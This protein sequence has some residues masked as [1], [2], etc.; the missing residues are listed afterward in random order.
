M[1]ENQM[2]SNRWVRIMGAIAVA[3]CAAALV[4]GV[5]LVRADDAAK[6]S[7]K[8]IMKADHKGDKSLAKKVGSGKATPDEVAKLLADYKIIADEKPPAGTQDDWTMR[9][10][11]LITATQA[12]QS[13]DK[14][15][16]DQ[17]KAAVSCKACHE[18]HKEKE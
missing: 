15:G 11:K 8:D 7:I 4:I 12:I 3:G 1:L 14:A 6:P 16:P 2:R 13:G 9:M 10:T 5:P 18:L 17:F